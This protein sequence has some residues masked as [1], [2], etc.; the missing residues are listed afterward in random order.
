MPNGVLV[1]TVART[2]LGASR[3][4]KPSQRCE[5]RAVQERPS[6][7]AKVIGLPR[8]GGLHYRYA[9]AEAA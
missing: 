3:G 2:N 5:G 9:W 4:V 1:R 6:E 8:V 7:R